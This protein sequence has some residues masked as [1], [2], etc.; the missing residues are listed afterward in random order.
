[1]KSVQQ[2][3]ASGRVAALQQMFGGDLHFAAR[4]LG[5][6]DIDVFRK[7]GCFH[8]RAIADLALAGH[9]QVAVRGQLEVQKCDPPPAGR[10]KMID[11]QRRP[12]LIVVVD[13]V[14]RRHL[15]LVVCDE[16]G[17]DTCGEGA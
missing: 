14:E 10:G 2:K 16:N 6:H 15:R 17:R 5:A 11:D 4:L 9:H 13:G 8:R 1:M 7:A 12:H 3:I